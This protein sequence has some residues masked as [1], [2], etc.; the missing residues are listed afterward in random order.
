MKVRQTISSFQWGETIYMYSHVTHLYS[1]QIWTAHIGWKKQES[2]VQ[3][4]DEM[5][6]KYK[7]VFM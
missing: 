1:K 5:Y 2:N 7:A 4:F 6:K 3:E